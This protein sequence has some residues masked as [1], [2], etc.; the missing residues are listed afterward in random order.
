MKKHIYIIDDD[1][2]D[3]DFIIEAFHKINVDC[4]YTWAKNGEQAMKQL[5]YM[6]PDIIFI[7]FNMHGM[8]GIECLQALRSLPNCDNVPAILNSAC[9]TEELSS[10]GLKA[11]AFKC[12]QKTGSMTEMINLLQN[13]ALTQLHS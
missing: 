4:N 2:D 3:V 12:L 7:D 8:N 6:K 10:L 11:G 5:R 1:E 13:V 9:M